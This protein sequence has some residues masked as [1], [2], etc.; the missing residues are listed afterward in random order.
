M[1]LRLR[2]HVWYV[3]DTIEGIGTI[4]GT[5]TDRIE[6]STGYPEGAP[7]KQVKMAAIKIIGDLLDMVHG[8]APKPEPKAVVVPTLA[9]WWG[10]YKE[11]DEPDKSPHTQRRDLSIMHAWLPLLGHLPL[12]LKP[13][14]I[15]LAL[16]KRRKSL[17]GHTHRTVRTVLTEDSVQR[18]RRLLQAISERAVEN[19]LIATNPWKI[20][21]RGTK[22]KGRH[23]DKSRSDRILTEEDGVKLIAAMRTER[24]NAL[25]AGSRIHERYVRFVLFMLETG[26]R[27]D[28][29]LNAGFRDE[30]A[31]VHVRGK[32]LKERDVALT[33][34]ARRLL[35]EQMA[36]PGDKQSPRPKGDTHPWWQ[37]E[38]A[39]RK[40]MTNA[41]RK[42]GI[43]HLSPHD[44]R[45]TFGH[46]YMLRSN[47]DIVNLSKVL[48]HA[49]IGVTEKHYAYLKQADVRARML[50]VMEPVVEAPPAP[51]RHKRAKRHKREKPAPKLRLVG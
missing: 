36:D 47:N 14:D 7:E 34:A 19:G 39:F 10:R 45:H 40:A 4:L 16:Q 5:G 13:A 9:E 37:H 3:R 12:D 20:E 32:G 46:R 25:G 41:C 38:S 27:I 11:T 48:G 44:L 28:E 24:P 17:T 6:K 26:L 22:G 21:G 49:N 50:A 15:K 2:R 18:E 30:G 43:L 51:K 23:Q 33:R 8:N 29:L 31:Y 42:A 35:D 1:H